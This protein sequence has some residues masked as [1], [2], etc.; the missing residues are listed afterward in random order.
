M[1]TT[2]TPFAA[3]EPSRPRAW[4]VPGGPLTA[5]VPPGM[6]AITSQPTRSRPG[7]AAGDRIDVYATY[8][9]ARPTPRSS[10]R[11]SRVLELADTGDRRRARDARST[12]RAGLARRPPRRSG[13]AP[14]RRDGHRRRSAPCAGSSRSPSRS[15]R[16]RLPSADLRDRRRP[17][18]VSIWQAILLGPHAG[19][20]RVRADLE[21][22]PP[23]PRALDARHPDRARRR[24][25]QDVRRRPAHGDAA[26]RRHLLPP[27][28]RALPR[29]VVAVAPGARGSRRPTSG[30]PGP[31]SSARSP[32]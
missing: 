27:R 12:L 2:V 18:T 10:A 29:G 13:L 28:P 11:T 14:G 19:R 20:E 16:R 6:V 32:R 30:S 24:A 7:S 9:T 15:S 31:S 26:R 17:T 3:G 21:L 22:G 5:T 25:E 4:R 1:L 23:D 8:A